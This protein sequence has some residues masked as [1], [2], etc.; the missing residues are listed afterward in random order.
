MI[1]LDVFYVGL[2]TVAVMLIMQ[3]VIV[4]A[5]RLLYPPPPQ[6]VYRTIEVPVA[7]P[8]PPPA[9]PQPVFTQP[10]QEIQLPEYEPRKPA[11][12]GL[13][14]DAVLPDGIQETRPAGL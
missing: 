13:R 12:D 1:F 7:Q 11:S 5:T 4:L 10:A 2:A 14:L 9:Q 6:V 8:P 3:I